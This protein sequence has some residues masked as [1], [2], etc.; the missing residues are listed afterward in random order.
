MQKCKIDISFWGFLT[1]PLLLRPIGRPSHQSSL[2]LK[3]L[4]SVT[5]F[6]GFVVFVEDSP[7]FQIHLLL[8][9]L[10]VHHCEGVFHDIFE[11]R[12]EEDSVL[13]ELTANKLF[14]FWQF[15]WQ[16]V[17]LGCKVSGRNRGFGNPHWLSIRSGHLLVFQMTNISWV[18]GV[19]RRRT[20]RPVDRGGGLGVAST[21]LG[22]RSGDEFRHSWAYILGYPWLGVV[23]ISLGGDA[24]R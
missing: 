15:L 9:L 22:D 13:A 21:R 23:E 7:H 14:Q 17:Y 24:Q 4:Q 5:Y 2:K 18:P 19:F 12:G 3:R 1:K 8:F 20:L 6:E 10:A 16:L 11:L